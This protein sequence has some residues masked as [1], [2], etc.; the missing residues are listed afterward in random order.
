MVM[1]HYCRINLT[2]SVEVKERFDGVLAKNERKK[3][4]AEPLLDRL[5]ELR[6][7]CDVASS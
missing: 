1:E 6:L 2:F 3:G 7:A 5:E 4:G